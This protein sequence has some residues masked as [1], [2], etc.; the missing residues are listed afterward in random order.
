M[1][2]SEMI[3]CIE[4]PFE[5]YVRM[6]RED[7]RFYQ[8]NWGDGEWTAICEP[9]EV[10][11]NSDNVLMNKNVGEKLLRSMAAPFTYFGT[12]CGSKLDKK[13]Y[14]KLE[15]VGWQ[16]KPWVFKETI[17]EANCNG[18]IAPLFREFTKKRSALVGGPHLMGIDIIDFNYKIE[19]HPTDACNN[20]N[21]I[22]ETVDR[23]A[24]D[25]DVICFCAG[26][27]TNIVMGILLSTLC[28]LPTMIDM[29]AC[30]DPYVGVFNRKRYRQKEWQQNE[31]QKIIKETLA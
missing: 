6:V 17:S 26:F 3:P 24:R 31:M 5:H 28:K 7:W 18:Y 30:F 13:V 23:I 22:S 15:D 10:N 14:N 21:A 19:I 25:V 16:G 29:G 8:A 1:P 11:P 4:V 2:R 9:D 12:N 20:C 27:A